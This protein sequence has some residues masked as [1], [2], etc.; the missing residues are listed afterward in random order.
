MKIDPLW[1]F[2]DLTATKARF[3]AALAAASAPEDQITCLSQLAR[4]AGLDQ[5]FTLGE[6]LLDQA[7]A[8][9][10]SP[11]TQARITLETARLAHAEGRAATAATLYHQAATQARN[12]GALDVALEALNEQAKGVPTAVALAIVDQG[13][14]LTRNTP[15]LR[16]HLGPLYQQT[17]RSLFE[18]GDLSG[19]L[20]MFQRDH[21]LRRS[22]GQ[23]AERHAA[24]LHIARTLR[25]LGRFAETSDQ[26]QNLVVELGP[27]GRG[28]GEVF[29]ERAELAH[30]TGKPD[31]ARQ[32]ALDARA[33]F[34]KRGMS[35]DTHP[36][37]FMRLAMLAGE[38]PNET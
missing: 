27:H 15:A 1:D 34:E 8:I 30:A 21:A 35:A 36:S 25:M 38:A 3:E 4:I 26:L 9:G 20:E 18:E 28:L 11:A 17:G 23:A 29:E 14:T 22:L 31:E 16:H 19:A 37:R 7:R 13:E 10:P 12:A 32:Y 6:T 33:R 24:G 2:D 5:D